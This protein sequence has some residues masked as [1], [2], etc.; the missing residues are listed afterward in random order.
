MAESRPLWQ[1]DLLQGAVWT[2]HTF[3]SALCGED[4]DV[5]ATSPDA[6]TAEQQRAGRLVDA[7]IRARELTVEFTHAATMDEPYGHYEIPRDEA[8]RWAAACEHLFPKFPFTQD[9]LSSQR[10]RAVRDSELSAEAAPQPTPVGT[11]ALAG[12][13][14][15]S[16]ASTTVTETSL[17]TITTPAPTLAEPELT[18]KPTGPAS[19]DSLSGERPSHIGAVPAAL[20]DRRRM[21]VTRALRRMGVKREVFCRTNRISTDV[22]RAVINGERRRANVA[23]WTPKILSLLGITEDDWNTA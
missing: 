8:I 19:T 13:A 15:R 18:P 11:D 20:K 17:A 2:H 22:L 14:G 12:K 1:T 4:P 16:D 3:L 7:A 23:R 9:D 6:W 5:A 10:T 21:L